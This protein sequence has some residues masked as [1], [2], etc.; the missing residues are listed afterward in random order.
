[1]GIVLRAVLGA[2]ELRPVGRAHELAR[3]R[4]ITVRP[5]GGST[6][7]V[8]ARVARVPVAA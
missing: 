1:M 5:G 6:V 3:R 7:G 2:Y 4:N 8:G